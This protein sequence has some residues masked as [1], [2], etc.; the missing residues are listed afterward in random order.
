M[1]DSLSR[2]EDL[3]NRIDSIPGGADLAAELRLEITGLYSR[4]ITK[5]PIERKSKVKDRFNVT[6]FFAEAMANKEFKVYYQPKVNLKT[7]TINGAEALSRWVKG[8]E[9]IAP[10]DYIPALEESEQ[11]EQLDFFVLDEV[12]KELKKRLDE[13]KKVVQISVNFSRVHIGKPNLLERIVDTIDRHSVPHSFI[14]IELTESASDLGF[15]ELRDL[16]L[17]LRDE[18][19]ST[20]VDDFGTGFS[21]LRL[22]SDLPWNVLKI[23]RSLLHEASREDASEHLILSHI[24][25][26]VRDIGMECIVEGV[27]TPEDIKLLKQN[28]CF[29]AQGYYFDRPLKTEDFAAIMDKF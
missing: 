8:G 24:I 7:Y 14:Q 5:E 1:A 6:G 27:E 18:G 16:I 22:I 21:S 12:C 15:D 17:G 23:D 10:D 20:A 4:L 29:T 3:L 13:H 19:I 11:I 2:I 26:M 28:D 9:L 25:S